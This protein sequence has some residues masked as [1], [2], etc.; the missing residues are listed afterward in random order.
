MGVEKITVEIKLKW[1]FVYLYWPLL[2]AMLWLARLVDDDVEPNWGRL[3]Y[4][5]KKAVTVKI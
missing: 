2:K 5:I 1:W 3:E 4:W